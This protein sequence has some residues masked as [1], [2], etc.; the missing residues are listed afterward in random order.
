MSEK[1]TDTITSIGWRINDDGDGYEVRTYFAAGGC[2]LYCA[3]NHPGIS[4]AYLPTSDPRALDRRTL[5]R[6][7]RQ[8][9]LERAAALG[10]SALLV[11]E[12][13]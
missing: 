8:T 1:T 4:D 10:V 3:G 9:A 5:R 2:D 6:L 11:S 13:R 7:A 12:E